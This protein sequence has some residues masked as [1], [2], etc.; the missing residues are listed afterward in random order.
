MEPKVSTEILWIGLAAI[1]VGCSSCVFGG[2]VG[3]GSA[4]GGNTVGFDI[5]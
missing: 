3:V 4:L 1:L 5:V 2:I